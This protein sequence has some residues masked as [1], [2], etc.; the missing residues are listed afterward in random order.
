MTISNLIQDSAAHVSSLV[1]LCSW[2]I[3][4]LYRVTTPLLDTFDAFS[5]EFCYVSLSCV[6][7]NHLGFFDSRVHLKRYFEIIFQLLKV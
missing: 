7:V 6:Y 4:H 1:Q 5:F 3:I 2:L